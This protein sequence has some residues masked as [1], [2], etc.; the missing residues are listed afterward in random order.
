MSA[1]AESLRAVELAETPGWLRRPSW[2]LATIAGV[3]VFG[4]P[5]VPWQQSA[6]GMGKVVAF[7]PVDR[8][9]ILEAPVSGRIVE[10]FVVEGQRVEV[11]DKI[12]V[13]EDIDPNYV[14]RLE[15][16]RDAAE[17]RVSAASEQSDA[18][19]AQAEA[20]ADAQTVAVE[21]ARLGV[22]MAEQ[23]LQATKETFEAEKANF[24]TAR[25]NFERSQPLFDDGL[26]SKR[27][28]E[29][30]ELTL[31]KARADMNKAEAAMTEAQASVMAKRAELIQKRAEAS[32]KIASAR[33]QSQKAA[34]DVAKAREEVTKI[35]VDIARQ[36]S[37]VVVAPRAGTILRILGS[38]GAKTVGMGT[39]LGV[40]VPDTNSRAV[41]LFVDGNDA[42]LITPGREVRLQ[43]EG[44][45]AVQFVGWPSVAVGTFPGKVAL[46]DAL[47]RENGRFRIVVVPQEGSEEIWP[48]PRYLR[49]GIKAKGWVLLNQV[50]LGYEVWRQL[51]GFP[52][53][54]PEQPDSTSTSAGDAVKKKGK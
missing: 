2:W 11:G 46:V 50:S 12:V 42:P 49:Q 6:S 23:K 7:A 21:G 13:L 45:P 5:I 4:L 52:V 26:I 36:N 28:L 35:E 48:E 19:G 53:S 37:R 22:R 31:A 9:Q 15:A 30:V 18:Y 40:L 47:G 24:G 20:L 17:A 3:V 10:W 25:L 54:L 1:I 29:L 43:F 34:S 27:D 14:N 32:A 33:A 16:N 41:E 39:Q 44:W 51:N 8:E 38:Q